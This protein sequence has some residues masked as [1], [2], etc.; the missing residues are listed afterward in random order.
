MAALLFSISSYAQQ[1]DSPSATIACCAEEPICAGETASIFVNLSGT[2]PYQFTYQDGAS[3]HTISTSE[4]VY[5]LQVSPQNTQDYTLKSM[6]D[7]SGS[8]SV[9]GKATVAVNQ[10]DAPERGRDCSIGGFTSDIIEQ[11]TTGS[12]TTYTVEVSADGNRDAL[13]HFNI[14]VPCGTVSEVSNSEGWPMEV[15]NTDPTTG[16]S[17]IKVDDIKDFGEDGSKDTFTVTF[18]VCQTSCGPTGPACSFVVAYKAATCVNYGVAEP[19]Y[20]PMEGILAAED[21]SCFGDTSGNIYLNLSYG[22]AP[23]T[24]AWSNGA[25]TKNLENVAAGNY[26][27]TITDATGETLQLSE[28]VSQPSAISLSGESTPTNCGEAIGTITVLASGGTAPYNYAW[29]HGASSNNISQLAAGTYNVSVTDANGCTATAIYTIEGSSTLGITIASSGNCTESN[30]TASVTGGNAPYTYAWN[31]GETTAAISPATSGTYTL[32]VTDAS[33]CTATA[34]AEATVGGNPPAITYEF[35]APSCGG[36]T[37]GAIYIDVTGGTAPYFISWDNG[38]TGAELENLTAGNY[39]VTV[40]DANGCST[41]QSINLPDGQ[42]INVLLSEV[43][44]PDCFSDYSYLEVYGNGGTA[45]YTYEWS[46]GETGSYLEEVAPGVYTVTVTDAS[47]CSTTR[48]FSINAPDAPQ[49]SLSGGQCGD[50]DITASVS[51]GTAPYTYVWNTGDNSAIITG[52]DGQSY[53]VTVTDANGCTS[54]ASIDIGTIGTPIEISYTTVSPTCYG[55]ANGSIDIEISG[56]SG[57]LDV[58]W[59]NGTTTEDQE[60][61]NGGTYTVTVTD[62]ETGCTKSESISLTQPLAINI[63]QLSKVDVNCNGLGSI[64]LQAENGTAPYTYEWSNGE[65]TSSLTDL[66]AGYYSVTVTDAQGCSN[67]RTFYIRDA[68]APTASI[69]S[70]GS[71]SSVTLYATV[72]GGSYPYTY[73]WSTGETTPTINPAE[74]GMYTLVITD[75]SG[76]T[77]E[78]SYDVSINENAL[79]LTAH[80]APVGCYGETNG[81]ASIEVAGGQAPYTYDWSN[82]YTGQLASNLA[83]GTYSVRVTDA[84]G[85]YEVVGFTI[86]AP[87][88]P[89][90]L[91][92]IENLSSNCGNANGLVEVEAMGGSAPYTFSWSNSAEGPTNLNLAP[93]TYTLTVTDANGCSASEAYTIEEE[94]GTAVSAL[95]AECQDDLIQAGEMVSLPVFVSG[96]GP[97]TLV[98]TDGSQT[99]SVEAS[100]SPIMLEVAPNQTTTYTLTS[101]TNSCGD[102]TAEGEVTVYVTDPKFEVC[103]ESCFSTNLLSANTDGSC[104]TYTLQVNAGNNCRYDLSHYE[105]AIPCG[106][107]SN[108]SNSEGWP[109]SVGLDPTTGVYGIKVDNIAGFGDNENFTITYTL[110]GADDCEAAGGEICN[111]WV[112]YKAGQCVYYGKVSEKAPLT[113]VPAIIT[114][115][116]ELVL[117]PNPATNLDN[118]SLKV[119]NTY[120]ENS[121]VVLVRNAT[122]QVIWQKQVALD[123]TLN[124]SLVNFELPL[125][126]TPGSYYISIQIG[127]EVKTE[128]LIVY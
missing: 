62:N 79:Q 42:P 104:S 101:I 17:G 93:G 90:S 66:T 63:R 24:Y 114:D 97:Y 33:G 103:G 28:T 76:C 107:V 3:S 13:S 91:N 71:C 88:S 25:T 52:A 89:I 61:I 123:N 26:S 108:M 39:T 65:T 45:P 70:G 100:A 96:E 120:L 126:L 115:N 92:L 8:G 67:T 99:Y 58:T 110:C 2:A 16:L 51:G 19:P 85:C 41:S 86:E 10:C 78:A 73:A 98:Y 102:G 7:A 105:V 117:Y 32:V 127:N 34:T 12:C 74:S 72:A 83:E 56:G 87:A 75:N 121:A 64:T 84:A 38:S 48:S 68:S 35:S 106:T 50:A 6:S 122:G 29:S 69:R 9:C 30:L 31:N 1:A 20:T 11:E 5:E 18:T 40:T 128:K 80:T 49:V 43:V 27:V 59:S 57:D 81:S 22:E 47:G 55:E 116:T 111:Q 112:S 37:D 36:Q 124:S 94:A 44:H 46:N 95:L 125:T 60:N 77:S 14:S 113:N 15:G 53:T 119:D 23:Y 118:V 21:A 109:M 4:T 82:G 54:Q